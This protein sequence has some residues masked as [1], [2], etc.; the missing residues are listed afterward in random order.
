M[1][2][3]CFDMCVFANMYIRRH[4]INS[5]H[6]SSSLSNLIVEA[7]SQSDPVLNNKANL[8]SQLTQG[9]S[10]PLPEAGIIGK[11]A[12]PPGF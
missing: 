4:K 5:E 10:V 8:A 2:V 3:E 9:S 12:C 6:L 1:C 7:V 11:L